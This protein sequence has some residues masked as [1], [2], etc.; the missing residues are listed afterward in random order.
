MKLQLR[1]SIVGYEMFTCERF[2][3]MNHDY[4]AH[5]HR[6]K[7]EGALA[8]EEEVISLVCASVSKLVV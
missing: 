8:F 2:Q 1:A 3:A 5:F 6:R 7:W 4:T